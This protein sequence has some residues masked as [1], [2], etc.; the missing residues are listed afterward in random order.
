M[1]MKVG[2]DAMIMKIAPQGLFYEEKINT[3]TKERKHV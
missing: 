1:I 3:H 2:V